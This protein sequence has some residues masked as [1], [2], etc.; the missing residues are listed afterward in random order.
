MSVITPTPGGP[1]TPSLE[2]D[3]SEV[4][5]EQEVSL[6][7]GI[8]R[9]E[10]ATD[11]NLLEAIHIPI[12]STDVSSLESGGEEDSLEEVFARA[13]LVKS[14]VMSAPDM[15]AERRVIKNLVMGAQAD[16]EVNPV[17]FMEP[18]NE[19]S[20]TSLWGKL[21]KAYRE[22]VLKLDEWREEFQ[23]ILDTNQ[24]T[25]LQASVTKLRQDLVKYKR[26]MLSKQ[27]TFPVAPP[28]TPVG[29]RPGSGID[30]VTKHFKQE[31]RAKMAALYNQLKI[32]CEG[33]Q[34][35]AQLDDLGT[36]W[37]DAEDDDIRK[38]MKD[39]K[40]WISRMIQLQSDFSSP[41]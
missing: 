6:L 17:E 19:D 22:S 38:A 4:R 37:Q 7:G 30:P 9:L 34:G 29:N 23:S 24:E 20:M 32:C 12:V 1:A 25:A 36:D 28:P 8:R 35:D 27:K 18:G 33:I 13:S 26:D 5:E 14:T 3:Y 10:S 39:K 21:D 16:M 41:F 15:D 31:A 40:R 11:P 2:W